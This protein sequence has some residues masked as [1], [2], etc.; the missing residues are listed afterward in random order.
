MIERLQQ[1][2]MLA[3]RQADPHL[4]QAGGEAEM[5]GVGMERRSRFQRRLIDQQHEMRTMAVIISA[6]ASAFARTALAAVG[7]GRAIGRRQGRIVRGDAGAFRRTMWAPAASKTD[8]DGEIMIDRRA[9]G[10]RDQGWTATPFMIAREILSRQAAGADQIEN[11]QQS[12]AAGGGE[13]RKQAKHRLDPSENAGLSLGKM[14]FAGIS[15]RLR[16]CNKRR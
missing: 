4:R 10:W 13:G 8:T 1:Q 5:G 3:R 16:F 7:R 6:K 2:L 14:L 11:Q 15:N 9:I 12:E